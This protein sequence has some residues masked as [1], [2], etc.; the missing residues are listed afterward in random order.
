MIFKILT[1]L[2]IWLK[3]V[4]SLSYEEKTILQWQSKEG[5]GHDV[6]RKKPMFLN[7]NDRKLAASFKSLFQDLPRDVTFDESG[8][9]GNLRQG[10]KGRRKRA[11]EEAMMV[12]PPIGSFD[13]VSVTGVEAATLLDMTF[14]NEVIEVR[15]ENLVTFPLHYNLNVTLVDGWD[16]IFIFPN[17]CMIN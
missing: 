3:T 4:K 1:L 13:R 7:P 15:I 16:F 14:S 5:S 10:T 2:L 6:L 8:L 12:E 11:A 9:R 17:V